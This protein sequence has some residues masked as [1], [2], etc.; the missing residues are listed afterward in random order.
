MRPTIASMI[1][2]AI[3]ALIGAIASA[4]MKNEIDGPVPDC[5][6]LDELREELKKTADEWYAGLKLS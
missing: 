4:A 1:D 5:V 2:Y 3:G 6:Q